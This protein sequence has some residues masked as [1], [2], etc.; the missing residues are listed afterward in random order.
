[1]SEEWKPLWKWIVALLV[2]LVAGGCTPVHIGTYPGDLT[3]FPDRPVSPEE[4]AE[5][6]QPYLDQSFALCRASRGSDWPEQFNPRISVKLDGSQYKVLKDNYQYK[7]YS[8]YRFSHAVLVNAETGEVTAAT[9]DEGTQ[10]PLA[11]DRGPAYRS[12]V[13]VRRV[14]WA[15]VLV[16]HVESS[17]QTL[18][19]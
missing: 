19:G 11:V 8:E 16:V 13:V 17:R 6:A 2:G 10:A 5:V 15:G 18:S 12:A 7:S 9:E 1:M 4:A 3:G 14:V